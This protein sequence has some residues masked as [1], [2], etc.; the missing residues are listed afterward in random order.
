M[1]IPIDSDYDDTDDE[2]L[3]NLAQISML[4]QNQQKK[5]NSLKKSD[6][7]VTEK[8][9]KPTLDVDSSDS[10]QGRDWFIF[11]K[12]HFALKF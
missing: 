11:A 3:N 1:I 10:K 5:E 4:E 6:E 9:E 8:T 7:K 12:T 2:I